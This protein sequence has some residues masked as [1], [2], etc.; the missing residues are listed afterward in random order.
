MSFTPRIILNHINNSVQ[1]IMT[2]LV[3]ERR[4]SNTGAGGGGVV[5]LKNSL[6]YNV[7]HRCL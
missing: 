4:L 7:Y 6:E 2:Y 1:C 5:I 3:W